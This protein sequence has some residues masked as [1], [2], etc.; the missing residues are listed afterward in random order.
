VRKR[1]ERTA[2]T[3]LILVIIKSFR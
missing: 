1:I 2:V 3:E